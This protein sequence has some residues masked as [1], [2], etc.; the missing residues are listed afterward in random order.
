MFYVGSM[1]PHDE[2]SRPCR[3]RST[4]WL[5]RRGSFSVKPCG[6]T[7]FHLNCR[8]T[9][10]G[11]QREGRR[12]GKP[13]SPAAADKKVNTDLHTR[14]VGLKRGALFCFS[15]FLH[16]LHLSPPSPLLRYS[17][18]RS[19]PSYPHPLRPRPQAKMSGTATA[20][21]QVLDAGLAKLKK[22][23]NVNAVEAPVTFKA[24]LM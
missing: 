19:T 17:P 23:D 12:A 20:P 8:G 18:T 3:R 10:D 22:T 16:L 5:S 14:K 9:I 2:S 13:G 4:F 15:F 7:E 11:G 6:L 24:Y 21:P 1:A